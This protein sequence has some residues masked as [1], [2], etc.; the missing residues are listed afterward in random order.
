M[1]QHVVLT[2][3]ENR[4]THA[5]LTHTLIWSILCTKNLSWNLL[6]C[7]FDRELTPRK[8]G[9][10]NLPAVPVSYAYGTRRG[11][12]RKKKCK[13]PNLKRCVLRASLAPK[14]SF[15]S[16]TPIYLLRSRFFFFFFFCQI[17]P[18]LLH[19]LQFSTLLA[20]FN[21]VARCFKCFYFERLVPL[22][23]C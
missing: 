13:N 20:H 7:S 15:V 2:K 5:G 12:E 10:G 23:A 6:L 22:C 19:I 21:W 4:I 17:C 1:H 11:E 3:H 16:L 8:H 9:H 18:L 14:I